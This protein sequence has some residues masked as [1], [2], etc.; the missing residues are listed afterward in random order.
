M[1]R[2]SRGHVGS[3]LLDNSNV[4]DEFRLEFGFQISAVKHREALNVFIN[5]CLV[6]KQLLYGKTLELI[7]SSGINIITAKPV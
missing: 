6:V 1:K 4:G 3:R 5:I 7:I 2:Q